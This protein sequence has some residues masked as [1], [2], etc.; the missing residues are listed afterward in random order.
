DKIAKSLIK[1]GM[2]SNDHIAF[3]VPRSELYMF[4]MLGILSIGGVYVPLDDT[5]PDERLKFILKDS[6]CKVIIVSDETN[7]RLS[8][9]EY[10]GTILNVSNIMNEDIGSLSYLPVV[11]SDL[12]SILYTSG[13]T[14]VSKGV[15]ITRKAILNVAAY[16]TDNYN[17]SDD[18]VYG[19]YPS[20]GFDAGCESLFKVIYAGAS[21]SIVPNEIR[22]D[23]TKLNKFFINQN[24]T[25]TIITTQVGKL[26]MEIVSDTSL[27]YLF[28]GGEK[29]GDIASPE[30][31]ILVDEYGPTE[32][33]NFITSIDNSNKI[34]FS[35]VGHL[36]YNS[37][38]Y[39]LDSE[40]RRVPI[41]AIGELYL[42]GHQVSDGYIGH[43]KETKN[44]FIK[45][46]FEDDSDYEVLYRTGDMVRILPDGSLGIVGRHDNQ[47]KIRGNRVELSEVE[48]V[49]REIKYIDDVTVQT[50]KHD[51][52]NEL[53]AYI[54][55]N[56][57]TDKNEENIKTAIQEYVSKIKPNY[58]VPSHVI[59]LDEIP[60]TVNGKV[61]RRA[62]PEVDFNSLS[63]E[64]I[65][66]TNETE[67]VIVNAFEK[68]FNQ[69]IGIYDDFIRLGGDSL[70]AIKLTSILAKQDINIDARELFKAETPHNIAEIIDGIDKEYGF[71]LARK[72][73]TNQNMFL[74]P[75]LGGLSFVYNEL[76]RD[77]DFDGNIYI[78][79]DYKFEL[80]VDEIRQSGGLSITFEKYWDAIKDIFQD[81]DILVGYSQG[82]LHA[83]LLCERLEK[84]MKVEKCLLI[85]GTLNFVND[86]SLTDE[87]IQSK[88]KN[89][90][91]EYSSEFDAEF[92]NKLVEVF[93][94]NLRWKLLQPKVN[95]HVLY[96][97]T[98]N[99]FREQL[100]EVASDYEFIIIDSTHLDI[101][102][103]DVDKI[104]K[105][106]NK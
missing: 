48:S 99:R 17:L 95:S 79:D 12:A 103:K 26:F 34:H 70:T 76:I 98:S 90:K 3:L 21:L 39:V 32:T 97:A 30:D 7:N 44:T 11:Y 52:N 80:P 16:Y 71:K 27:K 75:P 86:D 84:N 19:L 55:L 69:T 87:E 42:S 64:Y 67:K 4:N 15:K 10:D 47:V 88:I 51:S 100:D 82:C 83:L 37:K 56:N 91:E 94:S 63:V 50:I 105:Y 78:I 54:V 77:T 85:D 25:H 66:P 58:M 2:K 8:N 106:L 60:L 13:T 73:I 61:N 38:A 59:K 41:G 102:N 14:G 62:L 40:G 33:N 1:N 57:K 96:L 31:Y 24:V 65:A 104:L 101:I 23:M 6:N 74:L 45:N 49:I 68:V 18:D 46:P 53:V 35:S 72:G 22:F 43:E 20:I 29:L 9:L 92:I 36:N 93:I 89:L 81:G 28:V 5:L